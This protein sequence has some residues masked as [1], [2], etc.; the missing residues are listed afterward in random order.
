MLS[1]TYSPLL[2]LVENIG[3]KLFTSTSSIDLYSC[4]FPGGNM[5]T[6]DNRKLQFAADLLRLT[7]NLPIILILFIP[8]NILMYHQTEIDKV[9]Q[10]ISF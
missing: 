3:I 4:Y 8:L 9:R 7:R 5:G 10:L 6:N 1:T 2:K